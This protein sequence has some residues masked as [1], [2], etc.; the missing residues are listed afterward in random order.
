MLQNTVDNFLNTVNDAGYFN[1]TQMGGEYLE[2]FW[3]AFVSL[4]IL[5]VLI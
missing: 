2:H 3:L 4:L 5:K 1:L